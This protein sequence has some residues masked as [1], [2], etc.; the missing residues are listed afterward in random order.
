MIQESLEGIQ[1]I[2][3]GY[4][5]FGYGTLTNLRITQRRQATLHEYTLNDSLS[6]LK[7]VNDNFKSVYIFI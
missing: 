4:T 6:L 5:W 2:Y 3:R 7:S 1:S